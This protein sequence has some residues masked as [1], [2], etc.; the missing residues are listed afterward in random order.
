VRKPAFI[1]VLVPTCSINDPD[2]LRKTLLSHYPAP[3]SSSSSSASSSSRKKSAP[4]AVIFIDSLNEL[5]SQH[6]LEIATFLPSLI[7]PHTALVA[8][9]HSDVLVLP[10]AYN[11]YAPPPLRILS[12]MATAVVR[13]VN[14]AQELARQRARDRSLPEPVFGRDE[15]KEGVLVG[16][17]KIEPEDDEDEV[18]RAVVLDVEI[19]RRSGRCVG[20]V[21]V[22]V[23]PAMA[24]DTAGIATGKTCLKEEYGFF[25]RRRKKMEEDEAAAALGSGGGGGG[26]DDVPASTF[27]LGLTEKQRRD[28]DA[29]V[30][31]Y[32]DAQTDI[33]GGEGGRILYDIGRE[34]D[35]DEE[36][37]E[38]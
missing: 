8:T 13:I 30:L 23:R 20:E 17:C 6:R 2:S 19:R 32:F 16:L 21:Y 9:Y 33:G 18:R 29:V 7:S 25:A 35:F 31:P 10:P 5:L 15:R 3:E 11:E 27:D 1:D 28:R 24:D 4:T 14:L 37:D 26:A 34:D 38:I 22:L 36:E 12:H